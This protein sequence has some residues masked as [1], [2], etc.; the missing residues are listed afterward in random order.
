MRFVLALCALAFGSSAHAAGYKVTKIVTSAL[1][2][3]DQVSA[4][5]LNDKGQVVGSVSTETS[6]IAYIWDASSGLTEISGPN[7]LI[8]SASGINNLGQIVGQSGNRPFI[9]S[10]STG[11]QYLKT[12]SQRDGGGAFVITDS[13]QIA[14]QVSFS[15]D[16]SNAAIW[17]NSTARGAVVGA[18]ASSLFSG[19]TD[20][21]FVGFQYRDLV[22]FSDF[23]AI[24][25]TE[26]DGV[27]ALGTLG[28]RPRPGSPREYSNARDANALGVVV[29]YSSA[30]DGDR[31]F[32]WTRQNGM[33]AMSDLDGGPVGS[34]ARSINNLGQAVGY[35]STSEGRRAVIWNQ[36]NGDAID[37]NAFLSP[38]LGWTLTD[39]SDI[40]ELG[41]IVGNGID[42]SGRSFAWIM[43]PTAGVPEPASWA[44][45]IS[46]FGLAG[47][48]IRKRQRSDFKLTA[49]G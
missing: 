39:A 41:Q 31:A 46:G 19:G 4:N 2:D 7:Q 25:W 32:W 20:G 13:G 14:G 30:T 3:V 33:V 37:L 42:Q 8:T 26:V 44:L 34:R 36:L 12:P 47:L 27:T 10:A 16:A 35:G 1:P 9:W 40:N 28:V 43:T 49:R 15:P 45:M 23:E 18:P 29:G 17:D 6:A 38:S 24:V 5:R 22:G 11:F 21:I 48:S